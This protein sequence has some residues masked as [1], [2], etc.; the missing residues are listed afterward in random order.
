[1]ISKRQK[2]IDKNRV[3]ELIAGLQKKKAVYE[4]RAK[5]IISDMQATKAR[6]KQL[7]GAAKDA[8]KRARNI[9]KEIRSIKRQSK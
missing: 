9:E 2:T 4:A 5:Q 3:K 1:M 8:G 7:S 6:L